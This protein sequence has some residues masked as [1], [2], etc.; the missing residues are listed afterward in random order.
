MNPLVCNH[1][2]VIAICVHLCAFT[3]DG[4]SCLLKLHTVLEVQPM[5]ML[6][7]VS[8]TTIAVY[9]NESL[10]QSYR[11]S[12]YMCTHNLPVTAYLHCIT[13]YE[14]VTIKGLAIDMNCQFCICAFLHFCILCK[15]CTSAETTGNNYATAIF[16]ANCT[17]SSV[18]LCFQDSLR[19]T[20]M[21]HLVYALPWFIEGSSVHCY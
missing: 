18:L 9:N 6:T 8:C 7:S 20:H 19:Y 17:H 12:S 16:D 15:V 3:G 5:T 2:P 11:I 14:I 4:S 1:S 10:A 13:F 21:R